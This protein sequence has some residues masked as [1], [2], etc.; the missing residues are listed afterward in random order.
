MGKYRKKPVVVEAFRFK[1]DPI[2]PDWFAEKV[3]SNEIITNVD[4]TCIVKTLEGD[5]KANFGDYIIRG[6]EAIQGS[7]N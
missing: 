6:Q 3:S 2:M 5:H 1:I 7:G 4:G